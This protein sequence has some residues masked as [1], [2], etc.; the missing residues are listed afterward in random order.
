M[1]KTEVLAWPARAFTWAVW[2]CIGIGGLLQAH[3]ARLH[4][5]FIADD[6]DHFIQASVLPLGQLLVTPIDI[7]YVPLHK[8][9]SALIVYCAPL[10]FDLALVV[11]LAFHLLAA[12]LLYQL[13]TLFSNS[14]GNLLIVLLY[15]CNPFVLDLLM[16]WSSGIHRLPYIC[17]SLLSLYGYVLYRK[18]Q[19]VGPLVLSVLAFLVA[20]GFYSKALLIPIYIMAI[21]LCLPGKGGIRSL[22]LRLRIGIALLLV[23]L[24]Y[25]FWYWKFSPTQ[26]QG[27]SPSMAVGLEIIL[28]NFKVLVG[29]LAFYKYEAPKLCNIGIVTG[30]ILLAGYCAR[31]GKRSLVVW[32]VMFACIILNF[33]MIAF[34][35]R[36]QMFGGFIAFSL[37]YYLEVIVLVAL[38]AGVLFSAIYSD[39]GSGRVRLPWLAL[40]VC[41]LYSAT[42]GWFGAKYRGEIYRDSHLVTSKYMRNLLVGLDH[43]PADQPL[44]LQSGN[45]PAYVY[46]AFI[47][48]AMPFEKVL[49]MRYPHLRLVSAEEARYWVSEDGHVLPK[50]P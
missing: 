34:S 39:S 17:L 26:Q 10:N 12:V 43:V 2:C 15:A 16:W 37:R 47:N 24:A 32:G 11:L 33:A 5:H 7:H 9:F 21:E 30:L 14:R 13:L 20:F 40:L 31:R 36:G 23:S 44:L 45:L 4:S 50:L 22:L 27:P 29:G 35:N 1:R 42:L 3:Y 48:Q 19:R 46:G 38:F 6:Y 49:P 28:L 41:V 18:S 25:M 8:L